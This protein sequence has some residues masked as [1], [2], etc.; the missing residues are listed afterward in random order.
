MMPDNFEKLSQQ[1][2]DVGINEAKTLIGL[3]AQVGALLWLL[4]QHRVQFVTQS[5]SNSM[6]H[7]EHRLVGEP[8]RG[9]A[10]L[11]SQQESVHVFLGGSLQL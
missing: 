9:Q 5:I 8:T 6:L 7:E 1:L 11:K 10:N 4:S 2:L 3:I